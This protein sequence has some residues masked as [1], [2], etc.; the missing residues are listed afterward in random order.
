[1]SV[2][3]WPTPV[4]VTIPISH[5]CERARWALDYAGIDYLEQQHLQFFSWSAARRAGGS[6]QVPVLRVGS[7]V[8]ADS[9]D[10]VQWASD[11]ASCSLR[12]RTLA[13]EC[14]GLEAELAEAYGDATRRVAYGWFFD[15]LDACLTY[16]FG[17]APTWQSWLLCLGRP[18]VVPYARRHI[19]VDAKALQAAR[20]CILRTMDAI[21]ERLEDGRAF[22]LG[23]RFS[24]ADLTY[25]ALS[26]PSVLP[27]QYGM[28]LPPPTSLDEATQAWISKVRT[29]P[30]GQF[31]LRLYARRAEV[32]AVLA[33]PLAVPRRPRP[34]S[35]TAPEST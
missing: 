14:R 31:A 2:R 8:L 21:A 23:E 1:M 15:N 26:G 6:H 18:L 25:A 29:H 10:I 33:R 16:D 32:R 17:A 22:L 11:R 19:R 35:G 34:H 24:A 12:P 27:E 7:E 3:S 4:L 30:A 20:D 13:E 28:P 9:G 5:Y